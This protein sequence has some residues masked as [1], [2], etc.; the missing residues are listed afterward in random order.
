MAVENGISN[1]GGGTSF[2]S[3]DC[4]IGK[5]GA[6]TVWI[7][8]GPN[9]GGKS[10]FLRQVALISILG[11]MGSFIPADSAELG[12]IDQIFCRVGAG[13]DLYRD[14]ST[15]MVEM[16]ET[17]NILQNAT[18]R[19]LVCIISLFFFFFSF[20]LSFFPGSI[21]NSIIQMMSVFIF[22][23]FFLRMDFIYLLID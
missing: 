17:I 13:D 6:T 10:T 22:L 9:M 1:R 18:E 15:F 21:Y 8:T 16:N 11:Q 5:P 12:I 2:T 14:Q 7:I 19:S 3:N 20:L 4:L 23:F